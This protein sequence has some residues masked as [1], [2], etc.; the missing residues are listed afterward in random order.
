MK[1]LTVIPVGSGESPLSGN[2]KFSSLPDLW[3]EIGAPCKKKKTIVWRRGKLPV[4]TVP[5][6]PPLQ[7]VISPSK[8]SFFLW[9]IHLNAANEFVG[10]LYRQIDKQTIDNQSNIYCACSLL[11]PKET[12]RLFCPSSCSL[13]YIPPMQRRL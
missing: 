13:Q 5:L 1:W 11:F 12:S 9:M 6:L 4:R 2:S 7:G 10:V 3:E 8:T